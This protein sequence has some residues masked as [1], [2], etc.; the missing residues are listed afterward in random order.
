MCETWGR[1]RMR[2]GIMLFPIRI[3]PDLDRHQHGNSDPDRHQDDADPQ[4]C[5]TVFTSTPPNQTPRFFNRCLFFF[6]V[7]N[8]SKLT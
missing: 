2:I 4:H 8:D 7:M 6:V 5:C 1:I 3:H